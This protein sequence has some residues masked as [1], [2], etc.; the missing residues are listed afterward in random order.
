MADIFYAEVKSCGPYKEEEICY[1]I[2]LVKVDRFHNENE[3][4]TLSKRYS[5]SASPRKYLYF[6]EFK[7]PFI[8]IYGLLFMNRF[9]LQT[10]S[11]FRFR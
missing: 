8:R 5:F 11:T 6:P 10:Q 2:K 7:N 9:F 3:T 4:G 1:Q